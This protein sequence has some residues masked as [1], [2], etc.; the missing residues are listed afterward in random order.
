MIA[1]EVVLFMGGSCSHDDACCTSVDTL[2]FFFLYSISNQY[3]FMQHVAQSS[4]SYKGP[5]Y[6]C[7]KIHTFTIPSSQLSQQNVLL[8]YTSLSSHL[9]TNETSTQRSQPFPKS[10]PQAKLL[11]WLAPRAKRELPRGSF[12]NIN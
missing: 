10:S 6:A 4:I 11:P 8:T 3:D 7:A 2:L 12:R 1:W 9:R 5:F